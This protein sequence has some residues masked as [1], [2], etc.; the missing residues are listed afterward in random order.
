MKKNPKFNLEKVYQ[1]SIRIIISIYSS[2]I[3]SQTNDLND[4]QYGIAVK[5]TIDLNGYGNY[6]KYSNYNIAVV[7][8][9]GIHPLD[10][11]FLY[12]SIH[13]GVLLYNRGDLI[14]SYK[15]GFFSSTVLDFILDATINTGIYSKNINF[16]KR[17]VPLYH[18]SDFTPNPLQNPFQHSFS[19]GFNLIWSPNESRTEQ[20]QRVGYTGV[21]IDRRFQ[22]SVYNDG[23][24]WAK[25]GLA[26]GL[27]RFYTGGG[28][29]TYHMDRKN[30]INTLEASFHKFTGHEKYAFD[31]A[32]LLQ[33][34]F[35]P[36][37]KDS[38][39]YYSKSRF[40][41]T[42][43]SLKNNGGIHL[44]LHNTDKDPQDWIHF[45]QDSA[46]HPDVF[47]NR[48]KW[49]NELKRIGLGGFW[50]GT[51]HKFRN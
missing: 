21:M 2:C 9:A 11:N 8:G 27:D 3:Y 30:D 14:S 48:E 10:I 45:M 40:R 33:L 36:F 35:I 19:F 51:N 44:T 49:W 20:P 29:I 18:F 42:A 38:T 46:Y 15:K 7:G 16:N 25:T 23:S 47:Y 12:P 24:I 17:L 34:D 43:T 6:F 4:I 22:I 32:T 28:V 37:K 31:T 13:A 5:A 26:D 50:L 1:Y 41:F 39:Y